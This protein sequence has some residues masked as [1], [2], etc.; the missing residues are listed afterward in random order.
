MQDAHALHDQNRSPRNVKRPE[1]LFEP[2]GSFMIRAPLF[3]V[4]AYRRL[5]TATAGNTT[6]LSAINPRVQLAL[7][8]GSRSLLDELERD[9]SS[10]R[11]TL[12]RDRKL[13]RYLIRMATRP[14]PY[15][16]FAGVALGQWGET[17]DLTIDDPAAHIQARLDMGWLM[18]L[19]WQLEKV[20][21]VRKHLHWVTNTA[22]YLSNSRVFLHERAMPKTSADT[23]GIS[24]RATTAVKRALELAHRPIAYTDLAQALLASIPGATH[25]KVETLLTELWQ[26][27]LLLS[28]LRPPLTGDC[29]PAEYLQ[30]RLSTMPPTIALAESFTALQT[31]VH[32]WEIAPWEARLYDF[33]TL[34]KQIEYF[35]QGFEATFGLMPNIQ[36]Q[37]PS[38]VRDTISA[39]AL[40]K[41][42]KAGTDEALL[43]VDMGMQLAGHS[44]PVHV[45][46]DVAHMA[47]VLLRLTPIPHGPTTLAPYRRAFLDRYG[48]DREVPL[49]EL[50]DQ[51]FGLGVPEIA[52]GIVAPGEDEQQRARRN[53]TLIE[54]ALS[55]Q[56][57]RQLVVELDEVLLKRLEMW[58]PDPATAP[59]SLDLNIFLATASLAEIDAG[60]YQVVLGPNV[61]GQQAGCNLGRFAL[62]LGNEGIKILQEAAAREANLVPQCLLAEIVYLPKEDRMGNVTIRPATHQYELNYGISIMD[63]GFRTLG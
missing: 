61:G 45:G 3:P 53:H 32:A 36:T 60:H 27:T 48:Q 56:Q 43:Q 9:A 17:T 16:L 11:D 40:S 13:L 58:I 59:L 1:P 37:P 21:D 28:D 18:S 7:A 30:Q 8:V 6:E 10:L 19:I 52:N 41:P 15:G 57:E 47:E 25:E 23:S 22:V 33:R 20:P 26:Q 46:T 34:I 2:L 44:L 55:A 29:S 39:P 51:N 31:Q 42:L 4:E 54:L 50:V 38:A 14:T 5:G 35:T 49:V 24:L 63:P 12:R 62:L